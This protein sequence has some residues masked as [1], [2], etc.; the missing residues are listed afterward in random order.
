M[1]RPTVLQQAIIRL[2]EA[3]IRVSLF[4]DPDPGAIDTAKSLGAPAIELHTGRYAHTWQGS[5]EALK[6]LRAAAQRAAALG[7]SVHAGHGLTLRNVG[8]VA[9]IPEIEE[10]N[11]GHS[12]VSRAVTVGMHE[13]VVEMR[14]AID[15][16][17]RR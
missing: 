4:I 5:P 3:G 7:L 16:Q 14:Q 10:L 6:A 12:I 13:A 11:I 17:A 1:R 8:P 9:R 2:A 15:A